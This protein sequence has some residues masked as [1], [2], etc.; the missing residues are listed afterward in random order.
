MA[1]PIGMALGAVGGLTSLFSG[2]SNPRPEMSPE[3][4]QVFRFLRRMM[5]ERLQYANGIPGSGPGELASLAQLRGLAGEQMGNAFGSFLSAHDP[6]GPLAG[7]TADAVKSF[8]ESQAGNLMG[9]DMGM[10]AQF[11]ANREAAR[12]QSLQAAGM[13]GSIAGSP[14]G[15]M[16]SAPGLDP[17][18]TL[19][20]LGNLGY[21]YGLQQASRP[22]SAVSAPIGT[23][24]MTPPPRPKYDDPTLP[25]LY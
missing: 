9:I 10:M 6:R 24:R 15:G 11:L 12:G 23:I 14:A 2:D 17:G 22:K 16:S 7:S 4:M 13:A 20:M 1:F 5:K 18:S 3:Q 21:Q 8:G 25:L 19:G